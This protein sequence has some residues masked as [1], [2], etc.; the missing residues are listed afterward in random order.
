M[1]NKFLIVVILLLTKIDKNKNLIL[2]Y[3][4]KTTNITNIGYAIQRK[5]I[6]NYNFL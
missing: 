2:I 5:Y 4:M 1:N 6:S 3:T